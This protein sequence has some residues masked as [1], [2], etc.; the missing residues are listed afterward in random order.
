MRQRLTIILTFVVII[1]LLVLLN[2]FTYVK[3]EPPRDMEISPNRSTYHS[4]PTGTRAFHDL[5]SESG[6]KVIRW[7]ET[8]EK[9]A[10]DSGSSISTFVVVGQMQVPFTEEEAKV[11]HQWIAFGGRLILIDRDAESYL[12]PKV[13]GLERRLDQLWLS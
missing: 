3:D 5:L 1:G 9:L 2:T 11:L 4:G 12:L 10:G 7:R 6:Y 13:A 8:T